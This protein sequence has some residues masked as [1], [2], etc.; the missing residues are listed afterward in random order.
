MSKD[1]YKILDIDKKA[2]DDTI[3]K[4]YRRLAMKWHPD[5]N[6]EN[7]EQAETKFKEISAAYEVLSDKKRRKEYDQFGVEGFNNTN[8]FN[9]KNPEDVFEQFFRQTNS[10]NPF[11]FNFSQSFS[12]PDMN[13][14]FKTKSQG[15][16]SHVNQSIDVVHELNCTLEELYSGKVKKIKIN[17]RLQ[18][19]HSRMITNVQKI[20]EINIKPGYKSGTKIKFN[21]EGDELINQPKQNIIFV[22]KEQPHNK[23][24]RD[25]DDLI[26]N[27]NITIGESLYGFKKEIHYLD[28]T[29]LN[30][31]VDVCSPPGGTHVVDNYGMPKKNGSKGKLLITYNIKYPA[32][33]TEEQKKHL[34]N[35]GL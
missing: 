14:S 4:A 28:N 25:G 6:P 16:R 1:Y 8:R 31:G 27:M 17:K 32:K 20:L 34:K 10:Q 24:K 12:G 2:N 7:Q 30:F 35:I 19:S 21:G 29:K 3:K 5:K 18:D 33:I 9:R 26:Y 11:N 23:F 22:L 13:F 15:N